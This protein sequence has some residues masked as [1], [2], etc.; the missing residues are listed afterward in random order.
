MSEP[1]CPVD[2]HVHLYPC[3]DVGKFLHAAREQ[4]PLQC[5]SRVGVLMFSEVA[6]YDAFARFASGEALAGLPGWTVSATQESEAVVLLYEASP[7]LVLVSGWQMNTAERLEVLAL[8]TRTRVADGLS[9]TETLS[10]VRE[11]GAVPVIPWG[12]GKWWGVRGRVLRAWLATHAAASGVF[13]GD[14]GNRPAGFPEPKPMREARAHGMA[15]LPGSD[16]LN[17]PGHARRPG[18]YGLRLSGDVSLETPVADLKAALLSLRP[19]TAVPYGRRLSFPSF[20]WANVALR[21]QKI[22]RNA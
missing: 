22:R 12:F 19:E 9:L 13:L 18:S 7:A 5:A 2:T 3:Y 4:G 21:L 1:D 6:G 15:V 14:N 8:G 16:P 11:A 20:V 17:L 10:A